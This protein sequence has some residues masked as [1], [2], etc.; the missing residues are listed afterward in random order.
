MP[1]RLAVLAVI[2]AVSA[3]V[4]LPVSGHLFLDYD[5]PQYV[6]RNTHL[7]RGAI[8]ERIVWALTS[9]GY[10]SNWHPLTWLSHLADWELFGADPRGHHLVSLSLHMLAAALLLLVLEAYTAAF[11]PSA[12]AVGVFALHPLHVESVAWVSERKDVL[13]AVFWA[14][15]LGAYLFYVRRPGAVRYLLASFMFV[16]GLLSKPMVVTLP[17]VLLVLDFWPLGRWRK[18]TGTGG[19][20]PAFHLLLEKAPLLAL[21]A[22]SAVLTY[23]AQR[24][25]GSII[26]TEEYRLPVR[27]ANALVSCAAYLAKAVWPGRL[28]VFYPY[29]VNP[30]AWKLAL[31]GALVVLI[32]SVAVA[33]IRRRPYIAA[34]WLWYLIALLPVI[35]LVQVGGQA[36]ADR[37]TYIP[38]TGIVLA[39]AW[40]SAE[41]VRSRPR[42]RAWIGVSWAAALILLSAATARQVGYW[43]D[44][45]TL[46]RRALRV[47]EGNYLAENNLGVLRHWQGRYGEAEEHFRRALAVWPRYPSAWINLGNARLRLGDTDGAYQAYRRAMELDRRDA[48]APYNMGLIAARRRRWREAEKLYR[49]ALRLDP[50]NAEA[51]TNLASVLMVLGREDEALASLDRAIGRNPDLEAARFNRGLI[52]L[53]RGGFGEAAAEFRETRRINPASREAAAALEEVLKKGRAR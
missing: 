44:S 5:D 49:E 47:T 13:S 3:A 36:M 41:A 12:L 14:A 29:R 51:L 39:A 24:R 45:E 9:V 43:R 53:R 30:A 8:G 25:G 16:L 23:I 26:T 38:L 33:Q 18:E 17:L 40:L 42:L 50:D 4:Y 37:Y 34:G 11:W 2:L 22:C 19:A 21:S 46:Y 27:L 1:R 28:A 20:A 7:S 52:F 48:R 10:A 35:G 32:S 15:S 31:S 6:L